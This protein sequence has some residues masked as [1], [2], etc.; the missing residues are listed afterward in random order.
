MV[1]EK[2]EYWMRHA[3]DLAA[4]AAGAGEVPVGAVVVQGGVV[5]GRGANAPIGA[6]DPTAHAEIVALREAAACV[7]NYR[8]IGASLYVTMEP[9]VMC[10]GAIVHA[11]IARVVFGAL[12]ER[13]GGAGSVFDVLGCDRLNHRPVVEGGV[14]ADDSARML[15]EFFRDR[16]RRGKESGRGV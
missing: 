3:L 4:R 14:L 5:I 15:L 16:R 13:W 9:C 11:R 6:C 12:D 7:G 2:D 10:A 8:L 1:D